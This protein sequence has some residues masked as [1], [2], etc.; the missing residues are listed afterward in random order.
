MPDFPGLAFDFASPSEDRLH[1]P[2]KSR[3]LHTL[4]MPL[5]SLQELKLL[6]DALY[7]QEY[8]DDKELLERYKLFGGKPRL[9]FRR[10]MYTRAKMDQW[11]SLINSYKEAMNPVGMGLEAEQYVQSDLI[12]INPCSDPHDCTLSWASEVVADEMMRYMSAQ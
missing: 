3:I 1:E 7:A 9:V 6:R 12:G 4:I 11:L 10:E 2:M 5:W 8:Q